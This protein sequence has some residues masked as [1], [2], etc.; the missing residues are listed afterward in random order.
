MLS[1]PFLL[2]RVAKRLVFPCVRPFASLRVTFFVVMLSEA[3]HLLF[4]RPTLRF[5]QGDFFIAF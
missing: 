4:F 1:D 3:K 2:F 5:A